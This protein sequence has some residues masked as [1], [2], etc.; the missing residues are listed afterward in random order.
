MKVIAIASGGGHW[1]EL[2]LMKE[3]FIEE[4]VMWVTTLKGLSEIEGFKRQKIVSDTNRKNKIK[5]VKA[6]VQIYKIITEE[7]PELIITTGAAPG[8]FA[9]I[10][11]KF[12]KIKTIWIDSIANSTELSLSGRIAKHFATQVYTQHKSLSEKKVKYIGKIF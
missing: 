1:E 11:G 7:N 12:Y 5:M 8:L 4:D 2:V 9:V 6:F 10:I 3:A